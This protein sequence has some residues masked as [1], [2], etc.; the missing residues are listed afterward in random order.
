MRTGTLHGSDASVYFTPEKIHEVDENGKPL[1]DDTLLMILNSYHD[2]IQFTLPA[3]PSGALWEVLIDTNTPGLK[4]GQTDREWRKITG[5]YRSVICL[6]K[7][8]KAR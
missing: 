4:P 2:P 1:T 6:I 7:I 5:N 3:M 8:S